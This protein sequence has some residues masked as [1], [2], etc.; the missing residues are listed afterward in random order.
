MFTERSQEKELLDLGPEYYKHDEYI[1]C[2]KKLFLINKLLGFFRSTKQLLNKF[3]KDS[4]LLDVG[5]GGGLFI[6]HLSKYFP[7]MKMLGM[8]ISTAAISDAE[9]SLKT[10][11]ENKPDTQ[12]F[13]QLQERTQLHFTKNS[14]DI[15]LA[16][17]VCH[18]LNDDELISFLQQAHLAASK[19]VII[20][21]L[22]RHRLAHWLYGLLSPLLFRNR[23]I[24]HDGLISIRRGFTRAEWQLLL[25]KA[26]I[27]NYQLK[28]C[29]PFR[30][31]L[32]LWK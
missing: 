24:T 5:C 28:W 16:T 7:N 19:A 11:K 20:N 6:L 18:H 1:Q 17:L 32:I 13:F 15:I 30:W 21:D 8:D 26:G 4:T 3:S 23:L 25:H 14:F 10:W 22:Q 29:F 12:V 2:L 9:Q 27:H 31:K